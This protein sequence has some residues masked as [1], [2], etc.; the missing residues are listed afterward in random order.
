VLYVTRTEQGHMLT[1]ADQAVFDAF[2]D[3]EGN[4]R[5]TVSAEALLRDA[6]AGTYDRLASAL[7]TH[8][9]EIG[10]RDFARFL[11]LLTDR[12]GAALSV[13]ALGTM[14]ETGDD[15]ATYVRV[16]FTVG[17]ELIR[18][19]WRRGRLALITRGVLPYVSTYPLRGRADSADFLG[20][21]TPNVGV[22]LLRLETDER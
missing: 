8:R 11:A 3:E 10:T 1:L 20:A 16:R 6:L 17:E 7:P 18:L 21:V 13:R 14:A 2:A 5:L 9:R 22:C 15:A 19:K 4:A 12:R